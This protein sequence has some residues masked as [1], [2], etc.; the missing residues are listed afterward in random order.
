L[1]YKTYYKKYWK[2]NKAKIKKQRL[3]KCQTN[4]K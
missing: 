2:K 3:K 4:I 1:Y